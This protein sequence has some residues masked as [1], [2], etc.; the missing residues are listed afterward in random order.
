MLF[1]V[2]DDVSSRIKGILQKIR[3]DAAMQNQYGS[4]WYNV[5]TNKNLFQTNSAH[6]DVIAQNHQEF[7][8]DQAPPSKD[9]AE[10]EF[11]QWLNSAQVDYDTHY[12]NGWVRILLMQEGSNTVVGLT[13]LQAVLG[14][15]WEDGSIKSLLEKHSPNLVFVGTD[16]GQYKEFE[17]PKQQMKMMMYF[18]LASQM[19]DTSQLKSRAGIS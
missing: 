11:E 4:G 19:S 7:G 8:Y 10:D 13:S 18:E 14:M 1:G 3:E 6:A 16:D 2:Q 9:H 12:A 15:A 17:L 5:W